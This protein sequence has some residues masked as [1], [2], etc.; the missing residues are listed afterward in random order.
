VLVRNVE[1]MDGMERGGATLMQL[2]NRL[3]H[4]LRSNNRRGARLNIAAHY[5]LGNDFFSHF[6]DETMMYSGAVF[7]R[8]DMSLRQASEAKLERICRKLDLKPGDRVL[9][10]GT[11]WGG[12]AIHAASR[13]RCHV[14]TTTIS[15]RQYE[16]AQARVREAGLEDRITVLLQDYRD[17]SGKYDKLVSIEMIEA[18]GQSFLETYFRRCSELLVP[19]GMFALQAIT[20]ADQRYEQ[21]LDAVDFIQRYIFPG[22]SLPSVSVIARK[23]AAAT[24]MR[25]FHLEDIGP[26]YARTLRAWRSRFL[27]AAAT[28]QGMGFSQE[29][30]RMWNYYFCYCEGGF[31][32]RSIGAVQIL[33]TKPGSRRDSVLAL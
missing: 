20:I 10:I 17:L 15:R 21:A 14:T 16:F 22:G 11:G 8:D 12:F 5:D 4:R 31:E 27:A 29:F 24:D 25:I 32:E 30:M 6:L 2:V 26:H 7:E 3:L 23:V 19:D 9:E 1:V 28:I 18:V 33:F 13:Y